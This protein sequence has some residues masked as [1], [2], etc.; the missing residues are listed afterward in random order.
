MITTGIE[1]KV[2]IQDIVSNQVPSFI[3]DESPKFVDFLKTYYTSQEYPGG[4]VDLSENLD[5]YLKLDNL[6][7]EAIV[8]FT[9]LTADIDSDSSIVQVSS[10]KGFPKKYGLLKIDDEII[11]YTGITTNSFTGCVRGF[12]GITNYHDQFDNEELIFDSSSSNSHTAEKSVENLSSLFL[13]EFFEK[14][15]TTFS[16]G[17]EGVD[18]YKGIDVG[19][20]IKEV[21]SFYSS[22][23]TDASIETLLR[24]L[25]GKSGKTINLEQYL[26]KASDS[27]FIRREVIVAEEI[28]GDLSKLSGQT[29]YKNTDSE[30][31]AVIS[32]VEPF[33]RKDK[34][35]YKLYVY[36]GY[37]DKLSIE[38]TFEITPSTKSCDNVLPNSEVITVDSTIG[39]N[40]S[41]TIYSG[42]NIITYKE[43]S[44]NQFLGCQ[45]IE[46]TI[47]KTDNI[48]SDKTYYGFEDGDILK[49][50]TFRITG[51][52]SDI[53]NINNDKVSVSE[54]Q[55]I[56]IKYLGDNIRNP[57]TE[58]KTYKEIFANS[59]IYNTSTSVD[60]KS[61]LS[62]NIILETNIDK[63]QFKVGDRIE[64]IDRG[65]REVVY[66]LLPGDIPFIESLNQ[67]SEGLLN[68]LSLRNFDPD[69]DP[70]KL[71]SIRRRIN[72]ASSANI[73]IEY[74]N[75]QIISDIQNLYTNKIG[76]E[77][78]AYVA[79]NGLPSSE[80]KDSQVYNF[81]IDP[82]TQERPTIP[83]V[84]DIDQE[85]YQYKIDQT[86]VD[87]LQDVDQ[88]TLL[89]SGIRR[90]TTINFSDRVKFLTGDRVYYSPESNPLIGL[91]EGSYYVKV[92][93]NAKKINL[94]TSKSHIGSSV[95]SLSFYGSNTGIGTHTFTLYEHRTNLIKPKKLLKK[96]TLNPNLESGTNQETTP[97]STGM[98]IN[99]VEIGNYKTEDKI[100][101]GPLTSV[102]V[103]N[104]GKNYDVIN[105][106][107]L[108]VINP[109]NGT[110]ASIQTV[111]TGKIEDIILDNRDTKFNF[112]G[113]V[114][115][116]IDGG[117]GT[118]GLFAPIVVKKRLELL[119]NANPVTEGGGISTSTNQLTFI[120]DH[121]LVDGQSIVYRNETNSPNIPIDSDG[122][123]LPDTTLINNATYF[124]RVDNNKTIQLFESVV[125]YENNN[126]ILFNLNVTTAEYGYGGI[127]KFLVG[128][129]SNVLSEIKILDSGLFTNRKLIVKPVGINT[130][131]NTINF[132]NHGFNS[133][134][135]IEYNFDST[136]GIGISITP[137]IGLST[138][139]NTNYLVL[140]VDDDSFR[141]CDAG[142]GGTIRSNFE[143]EKFVTFHS[144]GSGYH[145]F[146]YPDIEVSVTVRSSGYPEK[147]IRAFPVIKGSIVDAYLYESGSGF[148]SNILNFEKTPSISVIEGQK[149]QVSPVISSGVLIDTN[150]QFS[151]YDYFSAPE[152]TLFDPTG[153]G[154]GAKL[155]ANIQD[156]K[157]S[158]IIIQNS[159]RGYSNK[160]SIEIVNSGSG[161]LF[162]SNVR[163][164]N[165]NNVNKIPE[166]QYQILK[167]VNGTSLNY[168]VSGYYNKLRETFV[169]TGLSNSNIIGWAYDGNPIYGPYSQS[170]PNNKSS[171]TKR[172]ESGYNLNLDNIYD[173]PSISDF[174]LGFFIEDYSFDGSGDLDKNNGRFAKTNEFP[175][176]VY[177]YY[178]T[179]DIN[180]N[181]EF[182]YFIGNNYRSNIIEDN[183]TLNQD[184]DLNNS[185]FLRN[186]FPYKISELNSDN[187]FII[188][189][190]EISRQKTK[191][192]SIRSGSIDEIEI[193]NSGTNYNVN[194]ELIFDDTK[195][196]GGGV[197]AKVSLIGGKTVEN[198]QQNIVNYNQ[199]IVTWEDNATIRI[200]TPSEH[201][202][203]SGDYVSISGIATVIPS[204][205]I[206][207]LE[208]AY[209]KITVDQPIVLT[210]EDGIIAGS[211]TT[212][213]FV[214]NISEKLSPDTQLLIGDETLTILNVFP[215]EN[216]LRVERGNNSA[217]HYVGASL[218]AKNYDF[219]IKEN[220]ESFDSKLN[221]KVYFNPHESVGLGSTG[222]TYNVTLGFGTS[223]TI[224]RSILSGSIYLENHKFNVG[225]RV[226]LYL[227]TDVSDNTQNQIPA[228]DTLGEIID[229]DDGD[230]FYIAKKTPNSVGLATNKDD[231]SNIL[232]Y[233]EPFTASNADNY[234]LVSN[235]NQEYANIDKITATVSVSTSHGLVNGD[236]VKLSVEPNLN[237]GIGTS[238][239]VKV[240]KNYDQTIG[241]NTVDSALKSYSSTPGSVDPWVFTTFPHNHNFKTGDKVLY[242]NAD[243]LSLRYG[244]PSSFNDPST[245][246]DP[247]IQNVAFYVR[248]L[249][250]TDFTVS[251]TYDDVFKPSVLGKTT[252]GITGGNASAITIGNY[253]HIWTLINPQI[254]VT[255]GNNIVFD[256][257][258]PSLVGNNFKIF[259]DENFSNEFIT[260]TNSETF[261]V[262]SVGT[263]GVSSDA[264]VTINYSGSLPKKLFYTLESSSGLGIVAI[265]KDVVNYNQISYVDS[266]YTGSYPTIGIGTTTDTTFDISLIRESENVSYAKSECS[267][268][269]YNT[270]SSTAIG[271]IK[272]IDIVS[273]GENYKK[274]P[275]IT[276]IESKS[277]TGAIL[278]ANSN[279]VG[280]INEV[281]ILDTGFEYSS[282]QTLSPRAFVS[283]AI[284]LRN[285]NI[286]KNIEVIKGGLNYTSPPTTVLVDTA[287][288][289]SIKG[290][291]IHANL[292]AQS[293]SSIDVETTPY[294]VSGNAE[295]FVENNS[296]GISI[297][298][299]ESNNSGIFTCTLNTPIL[300][301]S[302]DSI[303]NV[304]DLVYIEGVQKFSE[305]GSGFN[306]SD[307][308]YRFLK[309]SGY[310]RLS[311]DRITIDAS[312]YTTNTG[313]AKTIQDSSGTI[314]NKKN[315]PEFSVT[316]QSSLFSVGE[317]LLVNGVEVDLKVESNT[318]DTDLKVVGSYELFVDDKI[319][320]KT[321]GNIAYISTIEKADA[322]Y[323]VDYAIKKSFGWQST[324][325]RLSEDYQVLPDNDYYQT[326]SYSVRSPLTWDE[327]RTPINNLVHV[328]GMKN[329]ADTEII[330]DNDSIS[331]ITSA[332][333]DLDIFLDLISEQRI[334]TIHN[335]DN[336]RDID[337][338]NGISKILE[339]EKSVFIPYT[340]A[341]TNSVLK[342]DDISPEFS[343]FESEPLPYRDLFEISPVRDYRNYTFKLTSID[344]TQL[345]LTRLSILSNPNEESFSLEQ[346]SLANV[347]TGITHI[348]GEL[349]GEFSLVT[350]EFEETFLRFT[351]KDPFTTEYDIK[352][353]E[354][355]FGDSAVGVATTSIGFI[356]L[357]SAVTGVTTGVGSR[358]L[359]SLD[360]NEYTSVYIDVSLNTLISNKLNVVRLYA[361]HDGAA[362]SITSY[363]FDSETTSISKEPIGTF[364][365]VIDGDDF[366]IRY[367]N[368]EEVETVVLRARSIC[369]GDHNTSTN[370]EDTYH[371]N[372]PGQPEGFERSVFYK[373]DHIE[374]TDTTST[375]PIGICTVNKNTVD[376]IQSVIEVT[377]SG[378]TDDYNGTALYD[379]TFLSD[380]INTYT[381]EGPALYRTDDVSGIG[382]FGAELV[383]NDFV[384]N[385][386]PND[387]SNQG[388]ITIKALSECYYRDVDTI[389]IAPPL[390][391]GSVIET[392][393]TFQYFALEGER[394]NKKNFVLRHETIP[395]FAKTINPQD[396]AQFN[397][398]TGVFN[399]PNHFFSDEE[400]VSYTA[401][402]TFIGVTP[403]KIQY[404]N[405]GT[406]TD[407]PDTLYIS[408]ESDFEYDTFKIA[409]SPGGSAL[410]NLTTGGG[411]AHIF[412]M[413]KSL[414]KAILSIDGMVQS[415]IA[416][417]NITHNLQGNVNDE[418]TAEATTF[419]LSGITTVNVSDILKV[420][421]ELM[422]VRSVGFGTTSLGPVTGIGTTT[423][424]TVE[425]GVLGTEPSLHNDHGGNP[426]VGIVS[427]FKGSY[428]IINDEVHFID[429]PKGNA[430]ITR[431]E[432]NLKFQTS[433]FTGRAFLRKNYLTNRIYDSI[434]NEFN[435]IGRTF[436]LTVN[437]SSDVGIGTSGGNGLVLINGIY[438]TPSALN[439]PQNNFEIIEDPNASATGISSVRFT[440]LTTT[441]GVFISEEDVNQNQIPRGGLIISIGS[442]GGLGYAPLVGAEIDLITNHHL[443]SN[444]GVNTL[445][446]DLGIGLVVGKF[447]TE[448]SSEGTFTGS[449]NII[450]G[451]NTSGI[452]TGMELQNSDNVAYGQTVTN[453]GNSEVTISSSSYIGAGTTSINFGFRKPLGGSGYFNNPTVSI[454]TT[455]SGTDAVITATVGAGGTA[456]FTITT[457]GSGYPDYP[458]AFVSEPSYEN[459]EIVGVSRVGLGAT[460]DT[461][462]GLLMDIE[463]GAAATTGIGSTTSEVRGFKIKRPGYAFKKGDIF[464]PVG[465]VTATGLSS[466]IEQIQFEVLET[467][468]DSFAA[469][470]FGELEFIDTIKPYQ[471]GVRTR[472]PL[473]FKGELF[474]VQVAEESRMN[475]ENSLL[476]F[477]NGVLQNPGENYF[478]SG[479][480]SFTFSEPPKP[481]DQIAVF[482]YRGTADTDDRQIGSVIPTLERGDIVQVKE[483][484]NISG[485][486]PR[487]VFDYKESDVLETSPYKGKGVFGDDS[488]EIGRTFRPVSWTKQKKDLVL[489]G[490]IVYKTRRSLLGQ[491]YPT[492]NIIKDV[493]PGDTE[494][495][496]ENVDLLVYENPSA[497]AG[498]QIKLFLI[499]DNTDFVPA[500]FNV[501]IS[502]GS[503][504]TFEITNPG[505]GYTSTDGSLTLIVSDPPYTIRPGWPDTVE[506]EE[507]N[508]I[509]V[510]NNLSLPPQRSSV[511]IL[512]VA[513]GIGGTLMNPSITNS[514]AGYTVAP[515]VAAPLPPANEEV[516]GD[517]NTLEGFSGIVTSMRQSGTPITSGIHSGAILQ[518]SVN[519]PLEDMVWDSNAIS[520]YTGTQVLNDNLI[521][522]GAQWTL[523]FVDGVFT[524]LVLDD[525]GYGYP[526]NATVASYYGNAF[527]YPY[528]LQWHPTEVD[529]VVII[530][531]DEVMHPEHNMAKIEFDLRE[532]Y[533]N[534]NMD[535]FNTDD[536]NKDN[537][538]GVGDYISI[539]DT[540][541]PRGDY[542]ETL[543]LAA[544]SQIVAGSTNYNS[545]GRQSSGRP[546]ISIASTF[547]DSIY[548]VEEYD[549]RDGNKTGIITSFAYIDNLNSLPTTDVSD[550]AAIGNFSWGKVGITNTITGTY[551]VFGNTVD[552]DLTNYT[553]VQRRSSGLRDTG[554]LTPDPGIAITS[555]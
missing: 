328:S 458:Q 438:Q 104:S 487:R 291:L 447:V 301:F 348:D 98:L 23:G 41:G 522:G 338:V 528:E 376:V 126:P 19:N 437:G 439:N 105:E 132:K 539:T 550:G 322:I 349:Y 484:L 111:V 209:K 509:N 268:L 420:D 85:I 472:F 315:Y 537:T 419:A 52:I 403:S 247:E 433:E 145:Y 158:E 56:S 63:S 269:E 233:R 200:T 515:T 222:E 89:S 160:S 435:G 18:L 531:V 210:L 538:L 181:P 527:S 305:D 541:V 464:T 43:K 497:F 227:N 16:H 366:K 207:K 525:R 47:N 237:V 374:D 321:S 129:D 430:S 549:R 135:L 101:Y 344:G 512:T 46:S 450:T 401:T 492:T 448:V 400:E 286:V 540:S 53:S 453:I 119:F 215:N 157:I 40:P 332:N 277:G 147:T 87:P 519:T 149:A 405:G 258:D 513:I 64:I 265:S 102:N 358:D 197:I 254:E 36:V 124:V 302:Q 206:L 78:Y 161:A 2:K 185:G 212:E 186:T 100:Y 545:S 112:D 280:S 118:G 285:S 75:H 534:D 460:T 320:G 293:I 193:I 442:S 461:G 501:G 71:Y 194:D 314:I 103:V 165:V 514:G 390:Q 152:L 95:P 488:G 131:N 14:L 11:T 371:F 308:G 457:P 166:K 443:P 342:I 518:F 248:V 474:S 170:D 96:F 219:T 444:W 92:F 319:T 155:V 109:N 391:Y 495:Y 276:S 377:V 359:I 516:V 392:L 303:I 175:N 345:Q 552:A 356:D 188:E 146:K 471:D 508:L 353:L 142:I 367:T 331:G 9:T 399:V 473:F 138:S 125:D 273:R 151:G 337:V 507:G 449:S 414:S 491:I 94:Y 90:F 29:I 22:K 393:K 272:N 24:I 50:C 275:S 421:D 177:A 498:E 137:N 298:S 300:G 236:I 83:S 97:G 69:L 368:D 55:I 120:D 115:V 310:Q 455:T 423:I 278:I 432:N 88:E 110:D 226:S 113:E 427:V 312:E 440:G 176:G 279:L 192:E 169:D 346:E 504:D 267:K 62:S 48:I 465:L 463:V 127:Q 511:G 451:I 521:P 144:N 479:G 204:P 159:G 73:P 140:K 17:F 292:S 168:L 309:V 446:P 231:L 214:S 543:D 225:D 266:N 65:S 173:R 311:E 503:I 184:F 409:L 454:A 494:M 257:S 361:T 493:N 385:F 178:A 431:T 362:S 148:G 394:I 57:I 79:S 51:V 459:L 386:Y 31:R 499:D 434:E 365:S 34:V 281:E 452:S 107:K 396:T 270:L 530:T 70:G 108:R 37:D 382:T 187:D 117:N 410:T 418:V 202:F 274:L 21:R 253:G 411:N 485:Q 489:G 370:P 290:G 133:G 429:A 77:E 106:P 12:S 383:N 426:N 343:Q 179:V 25:F 336:A 408:L 369:F 5:Q 153:S 123:T 422:V 234:Y 195:T 406:L 10:T 555:N 264:S 228:V 128:E 480:A 245:N 38:G 502:N 114:S 468:S 76:E 121:G 535:A 235:Y 259:Y 496:V 467:Y 91:V 506:V 536:F 354:K 424:V 116:S 375:S 216:A 329:F 42:D 326:L 350:T 352:Y 252:L 415:P 217:I 436:T 334:D 402:S 205:P 469:W 139:A 378:S 229:I 190:N 295:L 483:Y 54:N 201:N 341:I 93:D 412:S 6:T 398:L 203:S 324:T 325:G 172:M 387:R 407:L 288:R 213:I 249:N 304:G 60:I 33:T 306:S 13:K 542:F 372:L 183:K 548:K 287:T 61:I 30:T 27:N 544:Q 223:K 316:T 413:S 251:E 130:L 99:G 15:K 380:S 289:D 416:F 180:N 486:N 32:E 395:I 218:T 198:I 327:V 59:W 58:N 456:I 189:T 351:P 35:Y 475:V 182:P 529:G 524:K 357:V 330:S 551:K 425:R 191:I 318:N 208:G 339:F 28:D 1:S 242:S 7:P 238:I 164:L 240:V 261:N 533:L 294:G 74:G 462:V 510:S 477:V 317:S 256:V 243:G 220:F 221:N 141:I 39:F 239:S 307:L 80:F 355:R 136:A 156:G 481:G 271:P 262:S 26:I 505:A 143:K 363:M 297:I 470:Q 284:S 199:S 389:N 49:K 282:D 163:S 162:E 150:I 246:D 45:G 44:I 122:N 388:T 553:T 335:F 244:S 532:Q 397:P 547:M 232:Y 554:S 379:V 167:D 340:E 260:D 4:P 66:P 72:K 20:F 476:I 196:E 333:T 296:N 67:N 154:S 250:G 263:V 384:V 428:N 482:F 546:S 224:N 478:F 3:L 490:D 211:A 255:K 441:G 82:E 174:P 241:I 283:P 84:I 171:A 381:Q 230:V 313:I 404:D 373:S 134:E 520:P 68:S 347:G 500:E 466:P 8:G 360:K 299:V 81:D 445:N 417:T 323:K 86:S 364:T 526:N 523:H 517:L